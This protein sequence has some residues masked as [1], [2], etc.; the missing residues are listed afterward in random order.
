[1]SVYLVIKTILTEAIAS[2]V[3][4]E[5][6]PKG[7]RNYIYIHVLFSDIILYSQHPQD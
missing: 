7:L 6:F 2:E 1:M 3:I 4:R 5:L